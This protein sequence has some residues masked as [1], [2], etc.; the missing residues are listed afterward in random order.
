MALIPLT[1]DF[2]ENQSLTAHPRRTFSSSSNGQITG[3]VKVFAQ[4]SPIEK[5]AFKLSAF[6]ESEFNATGSIDSFREQWAMASRGFTVSGS[7][8]PVSATNVTFFAEQ[9]MD[10]VNSSSM[11]LRRQKAVGVTRFEPSLRFT[12]DTLRKNVVKDVLFSNYRVKY[13]SLQWAVSNY[14][15]L[16]FFRSEYP[17]DVPVSSSLIYPAPSSS[18]TGE[19][20]YRPSKAFTFEFYINPRYTSDSRD[21]HDSG[22]S[23]I[24]SLFHAGT[25]MHMSSSYAV[26]LVTGSNVDIDGRPNGFRLLLQ[27]SSSAEIAPSELNIGQVED[28]TLTHDTAFGPYG[29]YTR[30]N[31]AFVSSDNSLQ[32]NKWHH[33]AI[34]WGGDS[35]QSGTGS[36]MIDGVEDSTFVIPSASVIPQS[37]DDPLG[38]P[39]ALFIGNFYEGENKADY[40]S[41]DFNFI[42]QFFNA[43]AANVEGVTDSTNGSWTNDPPNYT[44]RHPLEAEVHELK[45]YETYRDDQDISY[46]IKNG[47]KD[48]G[49][50]EGLMFYVPPFFTPESRK[51][52]VLLTP[53]Q[54]YR[55][56][57]DD[58]FN[59]ALSFGVGGH[60]INLENFCR[61]FVRKE[62]P[63]MLFL[64]ASTIN[65]ST[66]WATANE[67]LFATGSVRKRNLTVLPNDNGNFKPNFLLLNSGT[68]TSHPASGSLL[69]KYTNDFGTTDLSLISLTDMV[70]TGSILPGLIAPDAGM[71]S[72]K[73]SIIQTIAGASPEDPGVPAGSVLTVLQRTRDSSSN[74]VVFF[75]ASNLFYGNKIYPGTFSIFDNHITGSG[76]KVKMKFV[77]NGLGSLHR[78]DCSGSHPVWST[79][80]NIVYEEGVACI[81][82]PVVPYYGKEF[83]KTEFQG[84]QNIHILEAMVPCPAGQINSSSNPQFAKLIPSDYASETSEEFVYITG[85]NFHDENLNIIARTNLAQPVVKRDIDKFMFKVKIDF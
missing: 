30:G 41:S 56:F 11:S 36:F 26:S 57:T 8:L 5:E 51:R 6:N 62:Y 82:S 23:K 65:S 31:L 76:G 74:E 63:R 54:S 79:V 13:P 24:N 66:E 50:E 59:V 34:R 43:N 67:F 52:E 27:L 68:Y 69:R 33:V 78:A 29:Q 15:T 28:G 85:I 47:V 81:L 58:P 73:N 2:F 39:D 42:S 22:Q 40:A 3:S 64:T 83:F 37:F 9:Y 18:L 7:I 20:V 12:A 61:E 4:S 10:K 32:F 46:A 1:P 45:I 38:D 72:G 48:I 55:S 77:D 71:P 21:G 16:N 49:A 75:D 25:I 14:H 17:H 60:L 19:T 84:E 35:V 70:Y 44:M 80:G 53:F